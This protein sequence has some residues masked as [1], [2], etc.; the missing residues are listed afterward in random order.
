M[1][2][3]G[4]DIGTM[5][6]CSAIPAEK[7][8]ETTEIKTLRN[9]FVEV[10]TDLISVSEIE[11]TDLDILQINDG[12]RERL[13]II[14]EDCLKFSQIFGQSPKRPMSNGVISRNEVD[15]PIILRL[16]I[17][18]LIG[19][20]DKGYCV[21]SVPALPVDNDSIKTLYHEKIF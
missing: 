21:Y 10:D 6:I 2:V 13:F 17:E 19:K 4:L 12:S 15:A 9:M 11:N 20:T 18:N 7:N 16:M 14:S 3:V 1:K 8:S 5:N